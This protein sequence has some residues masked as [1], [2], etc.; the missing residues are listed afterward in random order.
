MSGLFVTFEGGEACG[1]STQIKRLALRLGKLGRQ[2]L[3]VHEP[4]F[5]EIGLAIRDLLLNAAAG[6]SMCRETE[7][8]LF[9]ASRAQLVRE[10]IRPA[11]DKG[12][13]VLS[14]RFYDSTVV[15]QGIGR[16]LDLKFIDALNEFVAEGC[17]PDR[18]IL[19]DLDVTVSRERQL[20]RVRPV[21]Q[22]DR[23]E[24]LSDAFFEKVRRGYLELARAEPDRV[25]LV[26]AS[27][28]EDQ[29]A[30]SIWREINGLL[31]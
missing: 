3:A 19:L 12:L 2:V 7:L 26:D 31:S 23:I 6:K 9:A 4:G 29:V 27:G 22:P 8:L 16:G 28:S 24:L 13:I 1:K 11:L 5:T 10:K 18:T 14:D 15:Y 21:G 30:E 25:K 17:R 20:R